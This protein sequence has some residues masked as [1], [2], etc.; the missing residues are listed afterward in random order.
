MGNLFS[1]GLA[2]SLGIPILWFG[3]LLMRTVRARGRLDRVTKRQ[4][5]GYLFVAPAYLLFAS[6]ILVPCIGTVAISL[7]ESTDEFSQTT[8]FGWGNYVDLFTRDPI[9]REAFVN[10]T[11]YLVAT[12]VT[13]V[14]AGLGMA[15]LLSADRRGFLFFRL[16]F[17]SPMMLAMVVVGLLWKFILRADGG[18]L[19]QILSGIGLD[20]WAQTPWL[21]NPTFTLPAICLISGWIYAG[22]YLILFHAAIKRIPESLPES[23]RLDGCGELQVAWHVTLPMLRDVGIV[24]VLICATG[25]FK[26]FD[27][28]Y[29]ISPSGMNG[30]EMVATYLVKAILDNR[31]PYYGS[32]IAVL[33][34]AAVLL[35]SL[36]IMLFQRRSEPLEY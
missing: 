32:T 17:F 14:L 30:T 36:G 26:A 8:E 29:V 33:M 2:V 16:L 34:T 5:T 20:S 15:L 35:I 7:Q 19:N 3:L 23:A 24:C 31:D 12:L 11:I 10:N 1:I 6:I 13:E 4:L 9:I 28:F 21:A 25:A 22:F 18:L 27:L